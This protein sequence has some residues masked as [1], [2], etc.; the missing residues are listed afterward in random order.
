MKVRLETSLLTVK[1]MK[2]QSKGK[3]VW[4]N[5]GSWTQASMKRF[6]QTTLLC[7][8]CQTAI[9][10]KKNKRVKSWPIVVISLSE[11]TK[12]KFWFKSICIIKEKD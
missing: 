10:N 11:V 6:D 3:N 7:M 4:N 5:T 1:Y 12:G 9:Q 8:L 2:K